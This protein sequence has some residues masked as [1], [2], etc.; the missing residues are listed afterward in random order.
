MKK[1]I[2]PVILVAVGTG[3]A[4]ATEAEQT[5]ESAVVP[6][7]HVVNVGPNETVC[8]ITDKECDTDGIVIC[9]WTDSSVLRDIG[10]GTMCGDPLFE[11]L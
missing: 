4:F 10:N 11:R 1:L 7:Y 5:K 2:I 6:G 3:A 9:T 8:E